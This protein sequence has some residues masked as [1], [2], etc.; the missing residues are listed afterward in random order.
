[1]LAASNLD[2]PFHVKHEPDDLAA[3]RSASRVLGV[4]LSPA[5]AEKLRDLARLLQKRAVPLGLVARSD[6]PRILERHVLDCLRAAGA[7]GEATSA[8]DLG[9]GAGLPGLVVAVARPLLRV[10]LVEARRRRV[11]FLELAVQELEVANA[12]VVGRR[13][14][15]L[16]DP[17]DLCFARAFAPLPEA[18]AAARM[19]LVPAGRLVYFAGREPSSTDLPS[20]VRILEVRR[21]PVLESSGPLVIM[22][23]Q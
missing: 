7:V 1:M 2:F 13:V 6:E 3:I 17:V 5:Q 19:L 18:W 22:T 20:D 8:Y 15:T 16:A 12:E 10:G 11:S 23:R 4:P 14:E 21:S 9:S